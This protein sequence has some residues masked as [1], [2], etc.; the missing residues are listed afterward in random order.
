VSSSIQPGLWQVV[1]KY[2]PM[3]AVSY[4]V[5]GTKL[6]I[7]CS[8]LNLHH[9]LSKM[10]KVIPLGEFLARD[11]TEKDMQILIMKFIISCAKRVWR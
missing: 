4:H 10:E 5:T 1:S 11:M 9:S 8:L 2:S 6:T 7:T 3:V